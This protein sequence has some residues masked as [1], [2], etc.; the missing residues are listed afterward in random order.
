MTDFEHVERVPRRRAAEHFVDLAYALTGGDTLV[1]RRD[2]EQF[3]VA[4]ADEVLMMRRST[5]EGDRVEVTI[6]LSWTSPAR[7]HPAS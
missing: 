2:G 3:T 1:L 7:V 4:V 6:E 5:S